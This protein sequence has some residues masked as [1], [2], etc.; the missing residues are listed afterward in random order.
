MSS[1]PPI[2]GLSQP[3]PRDVAVGEFGTGLF[4]E[5]YSAF[6]WAWAWRRTVLLAAVAVPFGALLGLIHGLYVHDLGEGW[7]VAWRAGT[8]NLVTV[9]F[10]PCLAAVVQQRSLAWSTERALVIASVTLGMLAGL[11]AGAYAIVYHDNLM[12]Q[13]P[14]GTA[15]LLNLFAAGVPPAHVLVSR[16]AD[17][18][19]RLGLYA[20]CGGALALRTYLDEPR[21]WREHAERQGL[22]AARQG[23]F[24]AERRLALLQA[25]VEP[26][27]LFNTLASVRSLIQSE[28]TRAAAMVDALAVYLRSTLPRLR[29]EAGAPSST[30]SAQFDLCRTFLD[31]MDLRF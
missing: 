30:V 24:E 8:A 11:T 4:Y 18:L 1:R 19:A 22:E 17:M 5:R 6:G 29:H 12:G 20:V 25:Q 3:L 7:A 9:G 13:A 31:L 28:P 21:R 10:G 23:K 2:H 16:A 15:G 27:F 26:H 14:S